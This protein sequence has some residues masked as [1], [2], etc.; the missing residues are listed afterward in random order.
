MPDSK[1]T[2]L[3]LGITGG[4]ACGK[5][6]A[7]RI[8]AGMGF[9][10]CD[11]DLLAHALMKKGTP[12]FQKVVNHFGS[13]ILSD[14]GEISR[15]VLGKIVFEDPAQLERL[16][17]LVHPAVREALEKWIRDQRASGNSGAILLPLL[18][19]SGMNDLDWDVVWSVSSSREQVLQRLEKRGFNRIAA[20]ARIDSQ[21]PL[22]EKEQ[23]ADLVIL[24]QGTLQEFEAAIRQAVNNCRAKGTS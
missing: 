23:M 8:L 6:E 15:P 10:V 12:V 18:Y 4:I 1:R 24:N 13:Q 21:M 11:A 14:D 7:G 3:I 19:E 5:S 20:E 22:N 16:N 17:G 2:A 9:S